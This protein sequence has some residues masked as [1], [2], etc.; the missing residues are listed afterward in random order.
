MGGT[1]TVATILKSKVNSIITIKPTDTIGALSRLL[2]EKRIGAA[3]VSDDGVTVA[4][5]I[6][7]RDIAYGLGEHASKLHALQVSALMT[8]TVIT[9][10][11][12]DRI[13]FVASTMMARNIR[14][15]PVVEDNRLCGMI[16][17]RDVLNVR[18]KELQ[19]ETAL[20]RASAN[21]AD[22]A[23]QDR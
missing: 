17:I 21:G 9:C 16:S 6:S 2:R 14:H 23:P 10:A 7:E 18:V 15:I 5:V 13:G 22:V 11:P 4:G 19:V 8:K 12:T 1:V 3:V 20:L